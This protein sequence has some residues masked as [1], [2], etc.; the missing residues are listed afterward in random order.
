MSA[1]IDTAALDKA[2]DALLD[3]D[4][5]RVT[6]TETARLFGVNVTTVVH[7]INVGK[8]PAE[9]VGEAR[10]AYAWLIRPRDAVLIWGHKLRARE[11]TTNT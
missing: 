3:P 6:A 11:T 5:P 2:L 9:R 8:L 4:L 1:V 7:A 10:K